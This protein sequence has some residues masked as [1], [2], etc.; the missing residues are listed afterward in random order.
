MKL[1]ADPEM[2]QLEILQAIKGG[3]CTYTE[4]LRRSSYE[5]ISN[6]RRLCNGLVRSG[7]L[8]MWK[9]IKPRAPRSFSRWGHGPVAAHFRLATQGEERLIELER[10]R[11]TRDFGTAS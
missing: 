3:A 11:A 10:E 9:A 1:S 7:H 5:H 2:R 4:I 6:V 8:E